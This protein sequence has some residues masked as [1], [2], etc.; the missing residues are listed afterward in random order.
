MHS[1]SVPTMAGAVPTQTLRC[2]W[3]AVSWRFS[4]ERACLA[5]FLALEGAEVL[6]GVKPANLFRIT[7]RRQSC[8][9]NLA[10]IWH[11][12]GE[13]LI[14]ASSLRVN[15][16]RASDEALLIL[17]YDPRLLA[18]RLASRGGQVILKRCGYPDPVTF[19]V[20]LAHLKARVS[21]KGIPHEIGLFLGYPRKDVEAFLGW[22]D[23]PA[24]CQRLWKIYGKSR[25]SLALAEAYATCRA[26]IAARLMTDTDPCR[27]LGNEAALAA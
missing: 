3:M 7:N 1:Y 23:V 24:S 11:R 19:E 20:I 27:I 16:L 21:E 26:E 13:R 14:A 6:S 8:G 9:R 25:R 18:R 10:E 17:L 5:G 15:V 2:P 12:H 22:R 4:E